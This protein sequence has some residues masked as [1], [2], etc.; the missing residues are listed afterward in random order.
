MG[1]RGRDW[2][3]ETTPLMKHPLVYMLNCGSTAKIHSRRR[4]NFKLVH[5]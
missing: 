1:E 4:M 3:I 2:A 5:E